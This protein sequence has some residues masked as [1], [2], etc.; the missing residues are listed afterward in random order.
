MRLQCPTPLRIRRIWCIRH[1]LLV[2]ITMCLLCYN[3]KSHNQIKI[4]SISMIKINNW[5]SKRK[6]GRTRQCFA[7]QVYILHFFMIAKMNSSSAAIKPV[8]HYSVRIQYKWWNPLLKTW[9]KSLRHQIAHL[10]NYHNLEDNKW[11]RNKWSQRL[12]LMYKELSHLLTNQRPLKINHVR[13][14]SWAFW[15]NRSRWT[16]PYWWN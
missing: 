10:N 8:R 3:N 12:K 14:Q 15:R 2:R 11:I 6:R 5:N 13:S 1:H 9:S 4:R 7:I 16:I